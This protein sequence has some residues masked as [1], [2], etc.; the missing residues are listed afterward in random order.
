M[1]ADRCPLRSM[2]M[3]GAHPPLSTPNGHDGCVGFGRKMQTV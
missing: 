1:N 3:D 2:M